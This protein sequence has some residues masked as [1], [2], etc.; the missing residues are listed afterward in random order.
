MSLSIVA[1]VAAYNEEDIIGAAVRA[2]V[3]DGIKVYFIDHQSTDDTL[4]EVERIRHKS[5]IGIET[6]PSAGPA[7]TQK[8]RFTWEAI[9]KRKE[10]IA[11]SLDADWFIHHDADEFRESP[12]PNETL[13]AG[14]SR[15]DAA[16]FNAIDFEVLNFRPTAEDGKA[17]DIRNR[18]LFHEPAGAWDRVQIKCWKKTAHPISLAASGGHNV[19]FA[20]RRVCPVR[21]LLRH[22]PIRS[23]SHGE[24]KVLLERKAVFDPAE[25]A[26]GWHVQYDAIGEGTSFVRDAQSLIRFD[27]DAVRLTL[28]TRHRG[29]ERLERSLAANQEIADRVTD[30]LVELRRHLDSQDAEM[31]RL[32]AGD[33]ERDRNAGELGRHLKQQDAELEQLRGERERREAEHRDLARH[34]EALDGELGRLRTEHAGELSAL[35]VDRDRLSE[36]VE[37]LRR[38][39]DSQGAT[40]DRVRRDRDR[41]RRDLE[42]LRAQLLAQDVDADR[43]RRGLAAAQEDLARGRHELTAKNTTIEYVLASRSWRMT[44]PLRAFDRWVNGRAAES[45]GRGLALANLPLRGGLRLSSDVR[46]CWGDGWVGADLQ[47]QVTASRQIGQIRIA[48]RIPDGLVD[49]QEFRIEL[50]GESSVHRAPPG[51]FELHVPAALSQG[52]TG[53]VR[54]VAARSWRPSRAGESQDDRELAWLV[55]AIEGR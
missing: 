17:E 4:A 38:L 7:G 29:V 20:G 53:R 31:T 18:M 8:H 40:V 33:Q 15:V 37:T 11:E 44:A 32:R 23:Q 51:A 22:Y 50:D 45:T 14:I 26:K 36:V 48:G 1:I 46:G 10:A 5:I 55:L 25:R 12:W 41:L 54:M 9:L 49:G 39:A 3:D 2:L 6:F 19:E 35:R 21:F 24:R 30:Q 34:L 28:L 16:G 43:L 27:P 13:L 52:A 47:F 42:T